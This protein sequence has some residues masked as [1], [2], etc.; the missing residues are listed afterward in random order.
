[1]SQYRLHVAVGRLDLSTDL[2]RLWAAQSE[3]GVALAQHS[4]AGPVLS[5]TCIWATNVVSGLAMP[6]SCSGLG[7]P[8]LC[9]RDVPK[10]GLEACQRLAGGTT[11]WHHG[12]RWGMAIEPYP[13]PQSPGWAVPIQP[14][15]GHVNLRLLFCR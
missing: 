15:F 7:L 5:Q 10:V 9:L 4:C 1:M 12:R 6:I 8:R 3:P 2:A 13:T 11:G 14:A